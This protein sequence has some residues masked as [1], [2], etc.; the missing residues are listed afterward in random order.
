MKSLRIGLVDLDTSHP[1]SFVPLIRGLGHEVTGV[2]DSGTIYP[3][4]YA[5]T[6]AREHRI[7]AACESL[8]EL[9]DR[10]D[11][12]FIHSCN[13]DMHVRHAQPFVEAGK[14][15]FI[16]KPIAGNV[17]DLRQMIDWAKQGAVITGGS[18][19]RYCN[20]VREW[21]EREIGNEEWVYG[22]VGCAVDEFNYG[23]HAYAMLHGLLGPGIESVRYLGGT[24]QRQIELTWKDGRQ[25]VVSIGKTDGYL[26]FYSTIVMQKQVDFIRV[27]NSRLYQALLET[28]L[29][30]LAGEAPAP[31][32]LEELAE[33]EMAAIA[34]K[35]SADLGGKS[36]RINEI[37]ADYAGYDGTVFSKHYKALI[38]PQTS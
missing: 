5:D 3:P 11:A 21:R 27:D 32:P 36:V 14:A 33:A 25:G 1:G 12:V 19:L 18:A 28:V 4:G 31:L 7:D 22:L 2:F 15:V 23:I 30:Y 17:V 20:E 37:P 34:A 26:P 16:D 38:F 8:E 24:V 13:W 6:F 10:V 35:L 9:V 29:P